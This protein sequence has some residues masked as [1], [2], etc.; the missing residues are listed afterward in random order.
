MSDYDWDDQDDELAQEYED[1]WPEILGT[2]IA[3][4][5][6]EVGPSG[7]HHE[8]VDFLESLMYH[9]EVSPDEVVERLWPYREQLSQ[10]L[11]QPAEAWCQRFIANHTS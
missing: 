3:R 9:L 11:G 4:I 10:A 1:Q 8:Y 6:Q 2:S 7:F 5:Q